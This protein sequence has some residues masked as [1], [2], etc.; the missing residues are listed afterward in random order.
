MGRSNLEKRP[1]PQPVVS[2]T[3]RIPSTIEPPALP[4]ISAAY[5]EC[6]AETEAYLRRSSRRGSF[7]AEQPFVT[8]NALSTKDAVSSYRRKSIQIRRSALAVPDVARKNSI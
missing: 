4:A 1:S 7:C 8:D 2:N 6:E 5:V 3:L